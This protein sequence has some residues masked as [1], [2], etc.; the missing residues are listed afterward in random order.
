M[1]THTLT[2]G[3][4]WSRQLTSIVLRGEGEVATL[5]PPDVLT[6]EWRGIYI[7]DYINTGMRM[8]KHWHMFATSRM[9]KRP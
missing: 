3:E 7:C 1:S 8:V 2:S 5:F 9:E 4:P 6:V